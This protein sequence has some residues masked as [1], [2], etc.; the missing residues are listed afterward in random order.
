M[1]S[2]RMKEIKK[3]YHNEWEIV[4][5]FMYDSNINNRVKR[6]LMQD[7]EFAWDMV[8][9]VQLWFAKGKKFSLKKAMNEV[10]EQYIKQISLISA[11]RLK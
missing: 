9:T 2:R 8:I 3:E 4:K 1:D 6:I 7:D 11:R 10:V 5:Q